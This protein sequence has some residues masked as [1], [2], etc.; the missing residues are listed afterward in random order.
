MCVTK[1]KYKFKSVD[2]AKLIIARLNNRQYG[3]SPNK[4]QGL[5]YIAYGLWLRALKYR[6]T[7]ERPEVWLQGPV[8]RAVYEEF[9][10]STQPILLD[11]KEEDVNEEI[12][13]DENLKKVL[14]T[15]LNDFGEWT[16]ESLSIWNRRKGTPWW[17][18]VENNEKWE[19]LPISDSETYEFFAR[20]YDYE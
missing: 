14:E 15:V 7:D 9:E 1:D 10:N 19:N 8:F 13:N 20:I 16:E 17:N 4:V 11:I 6:L 18:V 3:V 2:I 5:L 12:R